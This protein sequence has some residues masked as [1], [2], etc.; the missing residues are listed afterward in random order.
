MTMPRNTGKDEKSYEP[1]EQALSALKKAI[2]LTSAEKKSQD[3]NQALTALK[4][5]KMKSLPEKAA[6]QAIIDDLIQ[7]GD[8]N[9][10]HEI[11]Q[12]RDDY[13]Q[14]VESAALLNNKPVLYGILDR[15]NQLPNNQ[16]MR[17]DLLTFALKT[18]DPTLIE[19]IFK[20]IHN[21]SS[22]FSWSSLFSSAVEQ[23]K[24]LK[25]DL[26]KQ[27]IDTYAAY[28]ELA[29]RAHLPDY[30]SLQNPFS[31]RLIASIDDPD[32]FDAFKYQITHNA[33]S[34]VP[35]IIFDNKATYAATQQQAIKVIKDARAAIMKMK[36]DKHLT[37]TEAMN[38][39]FAQNLPNRFG[40]IKYDESIYGNNPLT[41]LGSYAD[42][43]KREE[44][45]RPI[46]FT[47]EDYT[48]IQ[49]ICLD[50]DK[51][52]NR[53][54]LNIDELTAIQ[55]SLIKN[56]DA[57]INF[58]KIFFNPV[59]DHK[60][61]AIIQ[62]H[63]SHLKD[64]NNYPLLLWQ[65]CADLL[66][67]HSNIACKLGDTLFEIYEKAI[68]KVGKNNTDRLIDKLIE[69]VR[70]NDGALHLV[71]S[72]ALAAIVNSIV[73]GKNDFHI[74]TGIEVAE[75]EREMAMSADNSDQKV[76]DSKEI[77]AESEAEIDSDEEIESEADT[78]SE[79]DIDYAT[80]PEDEEEA[81]SE[82]KEK[83]EN[84]NTIREAFLTHLGLLSPESLHQLFSIASETTFRQPEIKEDKMIYAIKK[85]EHQALKIRD[86][87]FDIIN[88][89]YAKEAEAFFK[90]HT[91]YSPVFLIG[92]YAGVGVPSQPPIQTDENKENDPKAPRL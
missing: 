24:K 30:I 29:S 46:I 42:L 54:R 53:I 62:K 70:K 63:F 12:Q 78:E 13:Q 14:V 58:G 75:K 3:I 82:T 16:K 39:F 6:S 28:T 35:D 33:K 38:L 5:I 7:L 37:S 88:T 15:I 27:Y 10:I 90:T 45:N 47:D 81:E 2:E 52:I 32:L 41:A 66:E 67:S 76:E 8:V 89:S 83:T 59:L 17:A 84:P 72:G 4:N 18:A 23:D 80:D 69:Y 71:T 56:T 91:K 85:S 20:R 60:T 51:D 31:L 50:E 25:Q 22:S 34:L 11:Y 61:L 64:K 79:I 19:E 43:I 87:L 65:K 92:Q 44:I 36:Q 49:L 77:K 21:K 74:A 9:L 55:S 68:R 1:A 48:K 86:T 73:R 57:A 40:L 26:A